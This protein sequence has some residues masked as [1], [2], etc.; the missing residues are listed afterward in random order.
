MRTARIRF[1]LP[2]DTWITGLSE[3]FPDASF[4]LLTGLMLEDGA[5]EL[6]EIHAA[7]ATTV[8]D[9]FKSQPAIRHY[10]QLFAEENR[11]LARYETTDSGL[12]EFLQQSSFPPEFPII[13]QNGVVTVDFT[14]DRDQLQALR[15][16][17][18]A[19]PLTYD[20]LA[21]TDTEPPADI[22][23]HRQRE[24]VEA[25]VQHGYY[26]VP[27]E[28]TLSALAASLNIDKSTASGILRRAEAQIVTWFLSAT[29]HD[30]HQASD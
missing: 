17:L 4:R 9:A 18:A 29:G 30:T 1:E 14:G 15:D 10:E 22:L 20:I 16:T 28:Q 19:S 26:A 27:R 13:V 11:V 5:L 7:D 12:Y 24:V 25:A 3:T 6:G 2:D 23:T 21:I 8:A